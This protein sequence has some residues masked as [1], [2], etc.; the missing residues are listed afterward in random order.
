MFKEVRLYIITSITIF[1]LINSFL[2][3][4]SIRSILFCILANMYLCLYLILR[5][6]NIVRNE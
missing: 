1:S 4:E 2:I 3:D 6:L 5:A